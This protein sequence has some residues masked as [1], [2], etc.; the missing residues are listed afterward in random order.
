MESAN[1]FHLQ[2]LDGLEMIQA[3]YHQQKFS[4]HSHEGFCIGVIEDGAQ[5]FFRTG[6][7]H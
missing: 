1:Y 2:E 7:N 5:Q 3:Q 4:R 6:E